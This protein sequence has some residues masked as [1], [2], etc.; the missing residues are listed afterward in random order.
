MNINVKK[1][2]SNI[3]KKL[4]NNKPII[5]C[6]TNFVSIND[7]ANICAS[8]N[9]IPIMS[10]D[11][12]DA[13][14]IIINASSLLINIGTIDK[15]QN[16]LILKIYKL[17]K[18]YNKLIVLD[19]VG[20]GIS[21][22][23]TKV[24]D[25]ILNDDY[26]NIIIKGNQNEIMKIYD[27]SIEIKSV[28]NELNN[29]SIIE[30]KKVIKNLSNK[31]NNK[32]FVATGKYDVIGNNKLNYVINNGVKE[33]E[34]ISGT[35]CMLG[36]LIASFISVSNNILKATALSCLLFSIAGELAIK[37]NKGIIASAKISLLDNI[38][39]L[40]NDLNNIEKL[41]KINYE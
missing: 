39:L 34:M 6:I 29:I 5:L 16:N 20:Y 25:L 2:F 33:L 36:G 35:G 26:S 28:N 40:L 11:I 17:A 27:K 3:K 18:K 24:V 23:R 1:T 13:S 38:V 41:K 30:L 12:N 10:N 8:I 7:V 15:T 32:I 9:A 31:Y 4:D 37:N 21:N 19:P 14:N 22:I